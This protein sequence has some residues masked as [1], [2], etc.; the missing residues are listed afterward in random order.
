LEQH[1]YIFPP[2][3]H[4]RTFQ[5]QMLHISFI[6]TQDTFSFPPPPPP[7]KHPVSKFPIENTDQSSQQPQGNGIQAYRCNCVIQFLLN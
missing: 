6:S 5:E 7:L 1:V 2:S 4:F 3:L